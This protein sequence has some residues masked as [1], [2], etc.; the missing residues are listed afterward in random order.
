MH[1]E[2][3]YLQCNACQWTTR[4][5]GIPDRQNSSDSWPEPINPMEKDFSKILSHLKEL[6]H[7]EKI[8]RDRQTQ[9]KKRLAIYFCTRIF[10][11]LDA[12]YLD[13]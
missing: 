13:R 9:A 4:D 2:L 3:Y 10:S 11:T 6:S 5:S 1:N 12:N 7:N 8:E